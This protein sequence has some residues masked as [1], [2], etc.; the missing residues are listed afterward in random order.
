MPVVGR[1]PLPE[2]AGAS[3]ERLF[4]DILSFITV[5]TIHLVTG[6]KSHL[7]T[8]KSFSFHKKIGNLYNAHAHY[9][10]KRKWGC[11]RVNPRM[12]S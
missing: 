4:A 1:W 10:T 9:I 7:G 11:F 5:A 2:A 12:T 8:L 3:V 6:K